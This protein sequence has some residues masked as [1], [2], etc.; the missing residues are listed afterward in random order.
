MQVAHKIPHGGAE[1]GSIEWH[2][3]FEVHRAALFEATAPPPDTLHD[4][5]RFSRRSHTRSFAR[6]A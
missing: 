5:T 6:P 4:G 3:I 2:S 1:T